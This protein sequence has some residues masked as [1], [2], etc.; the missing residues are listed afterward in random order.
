M[1]EFCLDC[2]NELNH[3]HLQ[4]EDVILSDELDV[5]EDC[6]Q[7][8]QVIVTLRPRASHKILQSLR[9][10]LRPNRRSKL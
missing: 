5:C 3:T 6:V 2:W 4:Q 10:N 1:A 8:K 7:L 9:K